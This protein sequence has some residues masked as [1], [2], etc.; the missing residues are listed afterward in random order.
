MPITKTVP[1]TTP[2]MIG[3]KECHDLVL[4]EPTSAMI[5]D[6]QEESEKVVMTKNGPQ[7]VSSPSL[8]GAN[9]LRRQVERL[10]EIKGPIDLTTLRRLSAFDLSRVQEAADELDNMVAAQA[11]QTLKPEEERVGA[12]YPQASPSETMEALEQRGRTDE[13]DD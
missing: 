10:G 12:I 7:L 6:A 5:L 3:K 4:R 8:A 1:L 2:V 9:I 11:M 13:Q